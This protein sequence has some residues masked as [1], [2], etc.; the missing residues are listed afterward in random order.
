MF[1]G[2]WV[3][4]VAIDPRAIFILLWFAECSAQVL[5]GDVYGHFETKTWL[6]VALT[7]FSFISGAQ[8]VQLVAVNEKSLSAIKLNWFVK[9]MQT[10][11]SRRFIYVS[12]FLFSLIA[13]FAFYKLINL[14]GIGEG[15]VR[16]IE[17]LK[18]KIVKDLVGDRNLASIL[19]L[20]TIGVA[21]SVY[22]LSISSS[23]SKLTIALLIGLGLICALATTGRLL[24]L[25]LFLAINFL[26]YSQKIWQIKQVFLSLLG[27]IL[28]FSLMAVLLNK[29]AEDERLWACKK[30][31]DLLYEKNLKVNTTDLTELKAARSFTHVV[32]RKEQ[33]KWNVQVYF[34]GGLAAFNYYVKTGTPNIEGGAMLPNAARSLLN[35]LGGDIPMRPAVNPHIQMPLDSNVYT[36]LFPVYHDGGVLAVIVWFFLLGI[37][38]QFLFRLSQE[39]EMAYFNYLYAISLYPLVMVIFEEAYISSPGFWAIFL[40]VPIFI[41]IINNCILRIKNKDSH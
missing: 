33:F 10:N 18:I 6:I 34:L 4:L 3:D 41:Q 1:S 27:F 24:L 23:K 30:S 9:T 26:L 15:V 25:L 17:C 20:F 13:V 32:N 22:F 28:I 39:S 5:F 21:I 11:I 12:I 35:H 14:T 38:H 36:A 7:V 16:P 31:V 29:K 8:I 40:S 2:G 37:I 19:K